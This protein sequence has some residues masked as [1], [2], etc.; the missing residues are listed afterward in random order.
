MKMM[1]MKMNNK[2]L[3]KLTLIELDETFDIFI[4]ANEVIWK[5][6]KLIIKSISDLTGN[7][8]GMN[9]DYIF[10]N[11]L[12]SKIY[13][14]NELIINT[15]IRNGTEILMIENNQKTISTLPIQT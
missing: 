8:L 11:K 5:I 6:K 10:I 14:N 3:I 4:P 12:T 13:S 2:I 7:P 15:D 9:T 1:V